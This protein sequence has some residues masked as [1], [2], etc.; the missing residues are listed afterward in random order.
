VDNGTV[1]APFDGVVVDKSATVGQVVAPG[2]PLVVVAKD[3]SVK[4][5][6][7]LPESEA[8]AVKMGDLA[9]IRF[10]DSISG[11]TAPISLVSPAADPVTRK[12]AVEI[13]L[14]NPDRKM[15]LVTT[16]NVRFAGKTVS[17][18]VVPYRF[19][20]YSF[21]E[22][23]VSVKAADGTVR[24]IRVTLTGC[25]SDACVTEGGLNVGDTVVAP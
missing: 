17:G 14:P 6:V 3:D 1:V 23:S 18:K 13:R 5:K 25:S 21:G 24:K 7:Y 12:V 16:A 9:E 2:M 8:S 19:V 10:A 11:V 20:E 4:V 22:P 15:V